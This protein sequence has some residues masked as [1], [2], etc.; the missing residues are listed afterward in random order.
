MNFARKFFHSQN[1]VAANDFHFVT[2]KNGS[3]TFTF[4]K[5]SGTIDIDWGDGNVTNNAAS[6]ASHTYTSS[7]TKNIR[8]T[9]GKEY[10]TL[11][12]ANAGDYT[13]LNVDEFSTLS[14]FYSRQNLY[15]CATISNTSITY[16]DMFDNNSMTA[17]CIDGC[18]SLHTLSTYGCE[19]LAKI[20]NLSTT[21]GKAD[22]SFMS[23]SNL[24]NIDLTNCTSLTKVDFPSSVTY[25]G[26]IALNFDGCTALANDAAD[27]LDISMMGSAS[28]ITFDFN[29]CNSLENIYI[30]SITNITRIDSSSCTSLDTIDTGSTATGTFDLTNLTSLTYYYTRNASSMEILDLRN[31]TSLSVLD[32][33]NSDAL[34]TV[35]IGSIS[36]ITQCVAGHCAVLSKIDTGSTAAA[37]AD[38]SN[39]TSMYRFELDNNPSINYI[40]IPAATIDVA[41]LF[42]NMSLTSGEVDTILSDI[43]STKSTFTGTPTLNISGTNAAPGGTYQAQCP[44]TTGKEYQY[45]LV[46]DSCGDGHA[47]WTITANS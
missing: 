30:G 42:N 5:S 41:W 3:V 11:L 38:L 19:V 17:L 7:A 1:K 37:T 8:F 23:S 16:L 9:Q 12:Y 15:V 40:G 35:H 4:T 27:P 43:F 13:D 10:I 32:F 39:N 18:T 34:T 29:T 14:T 33:Y 21:S 22:L 25:T 44:P 24:R 20:G 28:G 31:S 46:N 6:P 45:E 36:T 2:A 47:T 26:S